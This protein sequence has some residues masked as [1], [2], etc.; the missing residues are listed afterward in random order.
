MDT[1]FFSALL[2]IA[3]GSVDVPKIKGVPHGPPQA[4]I[5]AAE[6]AALLTRGELLD[7]L[8]AARVVYAGEAHDQALH[9]ALQLELL[10]DLRSRLPRLVLGLEMVDR[11]QQGALDAYASGRMS[12]A[13]FAA[14]WKKAWGYDF[15][16]YRPL[17]SY[18]REQG[19]PVVG[20][21]A[22]LPVVRQVAK[23]GL[24][25]LSPEQRALLPE[26]ISQT[27]DPRYLAYLRE[28]LGRHGPMDP[29]REARMLEAMAVWNETMGQSVAECSARGTVLVLA[30]TGHMLYRS[31]VPES[32]GSRA[33]LSQAVLVP[34][35]MD[36]EARPLDELLRALQDPSSRDIRHAD[37]FWLLPSTR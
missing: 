4:A 33:P 7:R 8:A 30:G 21:N 3:P 15:E 32:A 14:F 29:V 16:L 24:A 2:S 37:Y 19:V 27:R 12:E 6:G 31:G 1:L 20:L 10:R 22:P 18:A 13:E 36:G 9:H 23:G 28:E 5:V 11:T 26:R 17:L 34:Y 25:S 35:P